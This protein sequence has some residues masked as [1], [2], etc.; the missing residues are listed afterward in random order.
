MAADHPTTPRELFNEALRQYGASELDAAEEL[1]RRVLGVVPG[2]PQ[3]IHYLGVL[4]FQRGDREMALRLMESCA[5]A[6]ASSPECLFNLARVRKAMGQLDGAVALLERA[7]SLNPRLR[8]VRAELAQSLAIAGD[9][10][11]AIAAYEQCL[12]EGADSPAL[13]YNAALTM[14]RGGRNQ[15]AAELVRMS[16][17]KHPANSEALNLLASLEMRAGRLGAALGLYSQALTLPGN[18]A[19]IHSNIG[20]I[21]WSQGLVEQAIESFRTAV[22]LKP[23]SA[24]LHSN[25]IYSLWFSDRQEPVAIFAEHEQWRQRHAQPWA[26]T[27]THGVVNRDPQRQLKLAY[28]SPQFRGHSVGR[29]IE[30]VLACHDHQRFQVTLYSDVLARDEMTERLYALADQVKSTAGMNDEA[31]SSLIAADGID[32][33]VDLN[34]H[35]SASRLGVFARK[36]APVQIAYLGYCATTGLKTMDYCLTDR[37]LDPPAETSVIHSERLLH[38]PGCYWTYTPPVEA[39]EII[40]RPAES[41]GHITFGSFNTFSKIT[42]ATLDAWAAI[43]RQVEGSELLAIIAGGAAEN[44][45]VHEAFEARG[46]KPDRVRLLPYQ[47]PRRYLSMLGAADIALDPF[48]YAGGTT[49]LD[50]LY[51]GTPVVTLVGRVATARAGVTLMTHVGL[52]ELIARSP[53]EYVQ[54]AADLAGDPHRLHQM[55]QELRARLLGSPIA[56]TKGFTAGLEGAYLRAWQDYCNR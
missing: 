32:I 10:E 15:R 52:P 27:P 49:T 25:L 48:P 4:A 14:Q 6:L 31:L 9:T 39:P 50:S 30:P 38:L 45:H 1:F 16:L 21:R 42:P 17:S 2:Q 24:A 28:V 34:Q 35:M 12:R 40:A 41:A 19:E 13:L 18:I 56:D 11:R 7:L 51:M 54:I 26:A 47:T 3:A 33:L 36:P 55:R 43:L 8:D 53:Q 5:D 23:E 29:L 37:Y 44:G 22:R 46:V 20:H